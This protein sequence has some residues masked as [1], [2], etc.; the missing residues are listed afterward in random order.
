MPPPP[1][2]L[3]SRRKDRWEAARKIA[4]IGRRRLVIKKSAAPLIRIHRSFRALAKNFSISAGG[5]RVGWS[6]VEK[7][8]GEISP[9]FLLHLP[10]IR[11]EKC[12][13][14]DGKLETKKRDQRFRCSWERKCRS[15]REYLVEC[16]WVVERSKS[17][18]FLGFLVSWFTFFCHL[19]VC[20]FTREYDI[21]IHSSFIYFFLS[22]SC[23]RFL[24]KYG[25]P[26]FVLVKFVRMNKE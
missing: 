24:I 21:G 13:R 6:S 7:L 1:P 16:R 8:L 9:I 11:K 26:D 10:P 2:L 12:V 5:R 20:L 23:R 22:F 4:Y 15:M 25:S 17:S 18:R 3:A 14:G 19:F